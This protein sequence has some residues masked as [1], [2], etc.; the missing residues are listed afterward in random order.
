MSEASR[1]IAMRVIDILGIRV[2][3]VL[4]TWEKV[5]ESQRNATQPLNDNIISSIRQDIKVAFEKEKDTL[6][7]LLSHS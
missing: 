7:D 5:A 1:D 2:E 3:D 6:T 4:D